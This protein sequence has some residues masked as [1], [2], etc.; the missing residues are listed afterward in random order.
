M[1]NPYESPTHCEAIKPPREFRGVFALM[2]AFSLAGLVIWFTIWAT[3]V[4]VPGSPSGRWFQE[5]TLA[6]KSITLFVTLFW[7]LPACYAVHRLEKVKL[8]RQTAE[9]ME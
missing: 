5:Y 8:D 4:H 6:Y 9:V 1:M 2:L 7:F 3:F